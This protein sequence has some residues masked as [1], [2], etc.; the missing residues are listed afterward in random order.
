MTALKNKRKI[1]YCNK[2]NR[3][4]N[5]KEVKVILKLKQKPERIENV[6]TMISILL[7][8]QQN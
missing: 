2:K 3:D 7:R 5:K 4:Q 1:N 8:Q 6:R